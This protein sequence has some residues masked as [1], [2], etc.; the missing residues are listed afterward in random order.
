LSYT[1]PSILLYTFL[2]KMFNLLSISLC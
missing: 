1:G 2:S